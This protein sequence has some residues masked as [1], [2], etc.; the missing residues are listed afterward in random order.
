MLVIKLFLITEEIDNHKA[1]IST[2]DWYSFESYLRQ[3]S[4]HLYIHIPIRNAV[5]MHFILNTA[6]IKSK[7]DY[8]IGFILHLYQLQTQLLIT[9]CC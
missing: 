2:N 4:K 6:K 7:L 9:E 1:V 3:S 5:I 8:I